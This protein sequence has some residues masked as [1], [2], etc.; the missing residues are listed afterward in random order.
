MGAARSGDGNDSTINAS[1]VNA[2]ETI[3]RFID[4][5]G[6][7]RIVKV[8]DFTVESFTDGPSAT[9]VIAGA[10]AGV[11]ATSENE[12]VHEINDIVPNCK[13]KKI[14]TAFGQLFGGGFANILFAD[15]SM[16]KVQDNNGY[17]GANKGDSWLG[18]YPN[19]PDGTTETARGQ[20]RFDAGAYD[21]VRDDL[22][23]GRMRGRLQA[24]GGSAES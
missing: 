1:G 10:N 6:R 13:A 9:R 12:Q 4:P 16:R 3:N 2:A 20:Y 8:G 22:Y 7:K 14:K 17:G 18:P 21:E 19:D 15:G 24:G 5:S 23:L 11:Y